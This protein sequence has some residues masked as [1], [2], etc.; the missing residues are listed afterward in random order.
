[1]ESSIPD[2]T[3]NLLC[4]KKLKKR[5]V[6]TTDIIN[7][8]K[9]KAAAL[10]GCSDESTIA[11]P[12][13]DGDGIPDYY[14][15]DCYRNFIYDQGNL[16]SC[17]ACAFCAVYRVMHY[18]QNTETSF[19]PSRL[20]FYYFERLIEGNVS[21]DVG[22]DIVDGLEHVKQN[23]VCSEAWFPYIVSNFA[24]R[25][26]RLA[27][28]SAIKHRIKDYDILNLDENLIYNIK[29]NIYND[30]PVMCAFAIYNSFFSENTTTT[31]IVTVPDIINEELLGGHEMYLT[32]FDDSAR[33]FTCVNSWG[34][35][36]GDNGLCYIPYDYISDPN[37]GWQFTIMSI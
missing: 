13:S 29:F 36:W 11:I 4:V 17:T 16:G 9:L 2:R 15:I 35:D 20:Y 37:L 1:M 5:I 27:I 14:S 30:K 21:E 19:E 32:E 3:Q 22:A 26:S 23:G 7:R 34:P 24:K 33:M 8:R 12:D 25:P 31:G 10:N 18:I 28:G 6:K